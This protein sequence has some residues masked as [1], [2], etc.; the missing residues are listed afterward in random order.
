MNS[1]DKLEKQIGI[2]FK[3]KKVLENAF[4]H[5]SYLNEHKSHPLPSNEKLIGIQLEEKS[6]KRN[7]K[8]RVFV[9]LLNK[10]LKFDAMDDSDFEYIKKYCDKI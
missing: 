10:Y 8:T 4:I 3:N 5:R 6:E 2:S 9:N 1:L 7:E